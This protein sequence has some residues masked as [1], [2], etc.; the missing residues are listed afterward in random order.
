MF[1]NIL[2]LSDLSATSELAFGPLAAL[3]RTPDCTIHLFHAVVGASDRGYLGAE[4]RASIDDAALAHASPAVEA[5]ANALRA[6]G[7]R[8]ELHVELGS[9]FDLVLGAIE[10]HTIDLVV[11]PTE[12]THSLVRRVSSST[13]GRALEHGHV[14]VMTLGPGFAAHAA[15]WPGFS[16]VMHPIALG[17]DREQALAFVG[18]WA[19]TLG[20]PIDLCT[21]VRPLR[22]DPAAAAGLSAEAIAEIETETREKMT[23][24]LHRRA[25]RLGDAVA[26]SHVIEAPHIGEALCQWAEET[27]AGVIVMPSFDRSATHTRTMG[28]VTEWMVRNAP[29]PV[30]V[31]DV[32]EPKAPRHADSL[33][34]EWL[35]EGEGLV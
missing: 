31:H 9:A 3:G 25:D 8:V 30:L 20:A 28:S 19:A 34:N 16:R 21:V 23:V 13:T 22:D 1:R 12:G 18:R 29:C 33:A 7:L 6:L 11:I 35:N 15:G 27:D 4:T 10:R 2:L 5:Q 17:E 26:E 32:P 24:F 14:P